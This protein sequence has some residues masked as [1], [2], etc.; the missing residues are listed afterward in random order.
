MDDLRPKGRNGLAQSGARPQIVHFPHRHVRVEVI[1]DADA[2]PAL[3]PPRDQQ[4][5]VRG[6]VGVAHLGGRPL[7]AREAARQDE[8]HDTHGRDTL[9]RRRLSP[10]GASTT[11]ALMRAFGL[12]LATIAL[13]LL[14]AA[15]LAYPVYAL[16][17]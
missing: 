11:L 17:A 16:R 3:P 9:R 10:Q 15:A 13:T 5:L 12:F 7:G 1:T 14:L 2:V 4:Y 6:R 8:M